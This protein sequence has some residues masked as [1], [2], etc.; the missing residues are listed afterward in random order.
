MTF[1]TEPNLYAT[2]YFK[3]LYFQSIIHGGV[4]YYSRSLEFERKLLPCAEVRTLI[5]IELNKIMR[6]EYEF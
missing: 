4:D 1:K 2:I 5:N 3:T 6:E